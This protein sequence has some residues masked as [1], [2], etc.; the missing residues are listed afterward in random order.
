MDPDCWEMKTDTKS[1]KYY[2]I[3][4]EKGQSQ[5][6]VPVY[7]DD[8]VGWEKNFSFTKKKFYYRNIKSKDYQWEKPKP[9][10]PLEENWEER[11]S[12]DCNQIYYI[13]K[14]K[15]TSQW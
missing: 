3:N 6:G 10:K 9:K 14:E 5:W 8:E 7:D 15:N 13:N 12:T 11:R 4:E 1:G 2:S